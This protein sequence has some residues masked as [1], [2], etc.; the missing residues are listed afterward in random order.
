[1]IT[2][3]QARGRCRDKNLKEKISFYDEIVELMTK[4]DKEV[5]SAVEKGKTSC[6]VSC[7]KQYGIRNK[8]GLWGWYYSNLIV[9]EAKN[10]LID[11]GYK[12]KIERKKKE[13]LEDY[14]YKNLLISWY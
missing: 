3:S 13:E 2:A 1:L 7:I 14:S 8:N 10:R 6:I 9:K 12:V 4:I 5:S 11:Y